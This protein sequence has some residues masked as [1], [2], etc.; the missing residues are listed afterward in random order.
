MDGDAARLDQ[1]AERVRDLLAEALLH[2]EPA[3]EEAHEPRQLRDPDDLL[4]GD[5]GEMGGARERE[6]MVLAECRERDR[7]LDDHAGSELVD[8]LGNAVSSFSSPS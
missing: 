4:V 8:S 2:R 6:R 3:R 1:L 7:P 5:V